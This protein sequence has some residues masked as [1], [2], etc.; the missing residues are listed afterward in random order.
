MRLF[1]VFSI[2]TFVVMNELQA[3]LKK[4]K[5]KSTPF[6]LELLNFFMNCD[7]SLSFSDIKQLLL[8]PIDKVTIYRA[9]ESFEKKGLI[10]VVPNIGS[11]TKYALCSDCEID[12]HNHEHAHFICK[13]CSNTF[14]VDLDKNKFNLSM[15]GYLVEQ[16]NLV[17]EGVCKDCNINRV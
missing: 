1:F 6:R 3:I 17:V 9:L 11:E 15:N 12:I 16:V 13:T 4:H 14:C 8:N 10:H 5:L 2:N 7:S